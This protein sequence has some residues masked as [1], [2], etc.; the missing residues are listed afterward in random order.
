MYTQQC[1]LFN[2][3]FFLRTNIFKNLNKSKYKKIKF[4]FLMFLL[5]SFS[6]FNTTYAVAGVPSLL[7]H[8]GRLLDSSG[9]LLGGSFGTNYCFKF[10]FYDN[11]N[12]GSGTKL[13]PAGSPS[14]ITTQVKNGIIN[15]DIGDTVSGGDLLD[16]DYFYR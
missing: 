7:H 15:V 5:V 4:F 13:W 16:F 6:F 9:N 3:F 11:T 8:Q 10:S 2:K 1:M 12:V 14:K